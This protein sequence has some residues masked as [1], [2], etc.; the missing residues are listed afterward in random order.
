MKHEFDHD[1]FIEISKYETSVFLQIYANLNAEIYKHKYSDD[2]NLLSINLADYGLAKRGVLYLSHWTIRD[3]IFQKLRRGH[4]NSHS[5]KT[6]MMKNEMFRLIGLYNDY[7]NELSKISLKG[8]YIFFHLYGIAEQQFRGQVNAFKED[9]KRNDIMFNVVDTESYFDIDLAIVE[10]LGMSRTEFRLIMIILLSMLLTNGLVNPYELIVD[11]DVFDNAKIPDFWE[12]YCRVV[13]YYTA[14]R[15]LIATN[16]LNYTR[17]RYLFVEYG[18]NCVLADGYMLEEKFAD[19]ELWLTRAFYLDREEVYGKEYFPNKFGIIFE[20]YVQYVAEQ[21]G[22]SD[23]LFNVNNQDVINRFF[24]TSVGSR[25]DY[26]LETPKYRLVIECKSGI[27]PVGV[28]DA[29]TNA[30]VLMNFMKRIFD[31]GA[32]QIITAIKNSKKTDKIIVGVI[33]HAEK[34][35]LKSRTKQVYLSLSKQEEFNDI[36]LFDISDY[37]LLIA[38]L[39][40]NPAAADEI[41]D[42]YI[43]NEKG[44]Q[45]DFIQIIEIKYSP[46]NLLDRIEA[47]EDIEFEAFLTTEA[48]K[49]KEKKQ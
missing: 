36:L 8:G 14:S 20:R 49:R 35:F 17:Y 47:F 23:R 15:D 29:N 7:E 46:S 32:G 1:F 45:L 30:E 38:L 31:K 2:S 40:E 5:L 12:K 39:K 3:I 43:S 48:L 4:I 34:A 10:T 6:N 41:L 28:K 25:V 33:V 16:T 42:D 24:T 44:E 9:K 37:E 21:E 27:K 22:V 26:V 11:E 19:A 18:E 13:K